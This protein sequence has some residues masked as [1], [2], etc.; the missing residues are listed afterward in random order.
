ME[1]P[2]VITSGVP[3]RNFVLETKNLGSLDVGSP[4]YYRGIKVGQVVDYDF[5]ERAEA[6]DVR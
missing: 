4:V 1:K 3:G 6:V 2:P 5:D